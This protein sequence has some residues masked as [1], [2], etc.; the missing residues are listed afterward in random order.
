MIEALNEYEKE[1][2]MKLNYNFFYKAS[3]ADLS[4]VRN[5]M[6]QTLLKYEKKQL[7]NDERDEIINTMDD[8]ERYESWEE[9]D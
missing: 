6:Y 3:E 9:P 8:L 1:G 7:T 4:V 2:V 5:A